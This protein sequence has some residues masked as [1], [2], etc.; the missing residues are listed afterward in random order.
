MHT[1]GSSEHW[2]PALVGQLV[3]PVL[4][5]MDALLISDQLTST[6]RGGCA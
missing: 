4:W 1:V 3:S 6:E 2:S 5:L